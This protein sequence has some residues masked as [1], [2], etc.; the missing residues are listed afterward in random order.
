MPVFAVYIIP[1]RQHPLYQI[2]SA[3]MGYDVRTATRSKPMLADLY[4]LAEMDSWIG[5]A[6][7]FGFHAT[8]GDALEYD[9]ESVAEIQTRLE[10]IGKR[11]PPFKLVNGRF[12]SLAGYGPRSLTIVFDSPDNVIERLH[13]LV[14]TMVNVLY[15]SSPFFEPQMNTYP[16]DERLHVIRYG[17]PHARL[18]ESFQLHFSLATRIPDR[19]TWEHLKLAL[20]KRTGL[21][22]HAEHREFDVDTIVLLEQQEHGYFR[23]V[24]WFPLVGKEM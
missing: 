4:G 2:G 10:W 16:D 21:F 6:R 8:L 13:Y 22:E 11:I 19:Q 15:R 3:F 20:V 7:I 12:R 14:V 9:E 23:P 1:A 17:V 5:R 24:S 18:F